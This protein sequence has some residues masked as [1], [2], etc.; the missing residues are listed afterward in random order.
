ME[1]NGF[2]NLEKPGEFT[3]IVDIQFIAAMIHPGGGRND[4]PQRLK[5]QFCIFNC[6]L[7]SNTSIDK[8]FSTIGLGYFCKVSDRKRKRI[9][10]DFDI[11]FFFFSI[12]IIDR[13]VTLLQI[14]LVLLTNLYQQLEDYGKKPKLKCYQHQL[15]FTMFLIYVIFHE[16]GRFDFLTLFF[17]KYNKRNF[18]LGNA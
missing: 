9:S 4:I 8:I 14:L 10:L 17:S 13:N 5:R 12:S 18:D 15:V 2:Y 1:Q 7:P 3:N 16:F 11:I 6:T